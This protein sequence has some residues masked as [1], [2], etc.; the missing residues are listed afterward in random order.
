MGSLVDPDAVLPCLCSRLFA[1][2]LPAAIP[3]K[4]EVTIGNI[5]LLCHAAI[6]LNIIT[7]TVE[8]YAWKRMSEIMF[9]TKW[10]KDYVYS[11]I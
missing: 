7:S 6:S 3:I 4:F 2:E 10:K 11:K 8:I 9:A 1:V 5:V